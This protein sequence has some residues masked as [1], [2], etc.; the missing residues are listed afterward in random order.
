MVDASLQLRQT[1]PTDVIQL[2]EDWTREEQTVE[3][4]VFQIELHFI[5]FVLYPTE[6]DI[7]C[8]YSEISYFWT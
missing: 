6:G 3:S 7:G 1:T 4:D 2:W 8:V 5:K